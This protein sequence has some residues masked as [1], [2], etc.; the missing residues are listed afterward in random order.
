MARE[1]YAFGAHPIFEGRNQRRDMLPAES[2]PLR[3][4]EAVDLALDSED[5][6][7]LLDRFEGERGDDSRPFASRLRGNIGED[8]EIPPCVAPAQR[9]RDGTRRTVL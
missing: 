4:A 5:R 1:F 8:E 6:I 7:D 9:L 3:A 2:E